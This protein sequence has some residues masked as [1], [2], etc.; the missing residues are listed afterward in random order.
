MVRIELSRGQN[1]LEWNRLKTAESC[2]GKLK[3][4]CLRTGAMCVKGKSGKGIVASVFVNGGC[5]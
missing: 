1:L 2:K 3:S 5:C 4:Y